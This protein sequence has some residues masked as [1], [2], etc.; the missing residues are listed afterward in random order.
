MLQSYNKEQAIKRINDLSKQGKTFIFIINYLQDCSYIEET[1]KLD[2]SFI[3]YNFNGFTNQE[4][5]HPFR[6]TVQWDMK[7]QSVNQYK[8]SFDHVME[9]IRG[10]NS[11]LANLTCVTPIATNL[12]L[13]EI[14]YHSKAMYKLWMKDS[15]VVFSPEIFVRM[16]GRNIYSYPM[17]GTIDASLP[18]ARRQLMDNPKEMAEHAT[19]VDLIRN[20][21]SMVAEQV[22]VTRYRY[23]DSIQTNSGSILQTSSEIC[24]ILPDDYWSRL[25]DILFKLLPAGSITGAPKHKTM[26]VIA[27]AETYE[28]GFYTGITGYF[29]G[30]DLDSAVMIRF[31]EQQGNKFYFK[32]GGGITC[33]SDLQSEY[34]EMKQKVYVPIY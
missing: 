24:G 5:F 26:D 6:K 7:F 28:R 3:L 15:F 25:G 27:H 11:F 4:P 9:N 10:G 1:D 20:D 17:K 18:S 32:S 34:D 23:V 33:K 2:P 16:K 8:R 19:I 22:S 12:N 31:I 30:T 14:F 29:D 13:K 21:L